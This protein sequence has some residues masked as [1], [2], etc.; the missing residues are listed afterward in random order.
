MER[1]LAGAKKS[2]NYAVEKQEGII[3]GSIE[4]FCNGKNNWR[5]SGE[6]DVQLGGKVFPQGLWA[7]RDCNT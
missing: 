5:V 1:K 3:F 6:K 2:G 4:D 7:I